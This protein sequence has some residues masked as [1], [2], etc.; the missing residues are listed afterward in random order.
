[1]TITRIVKGL[2]FPRSLRLQR[3]KE[4]AVR[5]PEITRQVA[6]QASEVK[7][8]TYIVANHSCRAIQWEPMT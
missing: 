8:S 5:Q 3:R 1:M 7:G 2:W 6:V 4:R